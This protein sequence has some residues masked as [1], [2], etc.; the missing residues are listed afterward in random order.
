[1]TKHGVPCLRPVALCGLVVL[2]GCLQPAVSQ[3]PG[4]VGTDAPITVTAQATVT[5][6]ALTETPP[7]TATA[8]R[9]P[10]AISPDWGVYEH[11]TLGWSLRLPQDWLIADEQERGMSVC[12]GDDARFI[13][14]DEPWLCEGTAK[15]ALRC[16]VEAA[17]SGFSDDYHN[18]RV[19]DARTMGAGDRMAYIA[20]HTI[21]LGSGRALPWEFHVT[22]IYL[23]YTTERVLHAY[24]M[25]APAGLQTGAVTDV[26]DMTGQQAS[27]AV[28]D[29][30]C[31]VLSTLV[32]ANQ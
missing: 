15:Q 18:F 14:R 1:M 30:F 3:G 25:G 12:A 24:I 16:V 17:E 7:P 10:I 29:Q 9:A 4:G 8:T 26:A 32:A 5:A 6:A 31:E 11:Q 21:E 2:A 28:L 22:H 27:D 19:V 20:D 13:V 23:P